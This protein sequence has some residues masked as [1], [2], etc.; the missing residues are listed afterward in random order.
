MNQ[1]TALKILKTG[2]NVFVTGSAGTGKTY[3]LGKYI[4]Y[5]RDHNV[6]PDIVAPTGIAASHLG[7]Q[8]IHSFFGIGIREE[9]DA[10]FV[11]TL[12]ERR[13]LK[14]RFG[15][16]RV[17]IID[18]ISMV[19]PALLTS[20]DMILRSFKNTDM[21]FGGVQVIVSG[22]FFSVA[23]CLSRSRRQTFCLAVSRMAGFASGELLSG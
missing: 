2:K 15:E 11:A 20:M 6:F 23:T 4:K 8:T 7:G 22:D 1:N 19:S 3:L 12:T 14:K 10:E 9:V 21:P 13:Y 16:L 17:L 5:L 18:E